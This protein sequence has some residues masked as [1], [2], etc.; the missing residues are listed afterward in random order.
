METNNLNNKMVWA[1]AHNYTKEGIYYCRIYNDTVILSD[2]D[3][4]TNR[5]KLGDVEMRE[6]KVGELADFFF[7]VLFPGLKDKKEELLQSD[8]AFFKAAMA[9]MEIHKQNAR[10]I[11]RG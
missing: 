8:Q 7:D 9:T 10:E 1:A 4:N 3:G 11:Y 2:E 5:F 6:A